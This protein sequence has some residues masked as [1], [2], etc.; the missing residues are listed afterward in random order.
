[1]RVVFFDGVCGLCN[2][3]VDFVLPRDLK[4]N[5][6]FS[7]LQSESAATY[8]APEL[9]KDLTTIVFYDD[10]EVYLRS[11][12]VI[13]A[14][15]YLGPRWSLLKIFL[16]IP[17]FARDAIYKIIATNRYKWF[18]EKETCRLPSP[19]ERSRFI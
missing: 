17:A 9:T 3:F 1:M 5:L 18:G 8:L 7:P 11:E 12:A 2:G 4:Q 10:G 13:R 6:R 15:S 19:E 16:I 14:L